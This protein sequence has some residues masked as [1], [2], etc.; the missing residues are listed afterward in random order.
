MD[1]VKLTIMGPK[2]CVG[3]V[4]LQNENKEETGGFKVVKLETGHCFELISMC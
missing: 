2:I 1:K 3:I 4:A